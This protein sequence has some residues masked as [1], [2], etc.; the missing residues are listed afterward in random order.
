MRGDVVWAE[1]ERGV[2]DRRQARRSSGGSTVRPW[3]RQFIVTFADAAVGAGVA[4]QRKTRRWPTMPRC[5][6]RPERRCTSSA[7]WSA[8]RGSSS[9]WR[10]RHRPPRRRS[11]R[12]SRAS[13]I[14]RFAAPDYP[15]QLT[16]VP[17]D[18]IYL[19]GDQWSLQDVASNR[20]RTASTRRHAWDITTGSAGMVIAV[21]DSGIVAH[22][23]LA[24]PR[25][26]RLRLRHRR[27]QRQRWRRPRRRRHRSRRL[28][29]RRTVPVA[30]RRRRGQHLARHARRRHPRGEFQQ[31]HR[32]RRHR[33]ERADRAGPR[34]RA[35]RRQILR[36]PRRHDLGRGLAGAGRARQPASRQGHQLER[37][38]D[39]I[40]LRARSRRSSTRSSTPAYSSPPPRA[41]TTRTPTTMCRRAARG[42]STVGATDRLGARASYSNFSTNLDIS[43]PGGDSRATGRRMPSS[44][45]GT[46]ARP[47]QESHLCARATARAFRRRRSPVSRR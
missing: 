22:P 35:L 40:V 36:H 28:A 32:H 8:A 23:D 29:H 13:G 21:V 25:P 24:G 41:T 9:C 5:R 15:V 45:R 14:V 6:T 12:S 19:H 11:P 34:A 46:T 4:P 17:N 39:G 30:V 10:R 27:H 43:A 3:S 38:R 7:R 26:P 44:R 33:L 2:S 18:P 47:P 42:L 37:G 20:L 16:P 31:R 1:V